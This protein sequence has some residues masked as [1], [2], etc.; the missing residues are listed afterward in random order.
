MYR[1]RG[2]KGSPEL[3][4]GDRYAKQAPMNRCL[5]L[6]GGVSENGFAVVIWHKKRKMCADEYAEA[7]GAGALTKAIKSLKPARPNGSP[8]H[9]QI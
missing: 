3:S 7:V 4:G 8:S 1:K 5:P 9:T 2:E 6:W